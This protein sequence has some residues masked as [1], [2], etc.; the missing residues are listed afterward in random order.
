MAILAPSR[1][2]L[3]QAGILLFGAGLW[4]GAVA[5]FSNRLEIPSENA[6]IALV[7]ALKK[8]P[9]PIWIDARSTAEYRNKHVP[10]AFLL[11]TENWEEAIP[12]LLERWE[13]DQPVVVYCN[14]S[15]AQASREIAERLRDFK[16]GPV[17]VLQGG[18][19]SWDRK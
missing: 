4:A 19:K 1:T 16:L 17:F 18:W 8:Q 7:D 3:I 9:P 13:P 10:G 5:A 2:V 12:T 14:S 15:G 11:N 6:E